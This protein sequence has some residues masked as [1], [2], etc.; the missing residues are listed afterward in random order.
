MIGHPGD[1]GPAV[2]SAEFKQYIQDALDLVEFCRG[3]VSTKWGAVRV[4]MGHEKP[5]ELKYIG[6]GNVSS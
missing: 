4:A 3:D 2:N 6:I 1:P 5:F